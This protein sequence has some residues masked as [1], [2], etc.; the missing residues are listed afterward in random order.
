MRLVELFKE[1][2]TKRI[3][4]QSPDNSSVHSI[5]KWNL[6]TTENVMLHGCVIK[7]DKI[8]T[9]LLKLETFKDHVIQNI[10]SIDRKISIWC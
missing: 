4:H 3:F 8:D 2:N 7:L 5:N 1:Y 10:L 6:L 9:K